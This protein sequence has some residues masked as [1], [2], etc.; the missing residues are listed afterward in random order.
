[1]RFKFI[2]NG[3]NDPPQVTLRGVIFPLGQ[4]VDVT[5]ADLIA[6]LAANSHFEVAKGRPAKAKADAEDD[7]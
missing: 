7:A 6:K 5:D 4:A 3:D 1:M 2:G